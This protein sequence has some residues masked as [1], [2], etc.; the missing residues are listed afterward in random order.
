MRR[1]PVIGLAIPG[2]KL[3]HR[4]IGREEFQRA[5]QLLHARAVAADHGKADRRRLWPRRDRARQIG[6]H[7]AFGALGDIGE[8]QRAAGRQLFGGRSGR[9]LHASASARR[10]DLMRVEQPPA[11]FRRQRPARRSARHRGRGRAARSDARARPVRSSVRSAISASA[12]RPRMRSISRVPRCQQ[13][14]NSRLRR[15]SRPSLDR[16]VPVICRFQSKRQKPGRA[17]RG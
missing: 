17:G 14:N 8:G 3:Q 13:R 4:Q 12:K 15:S 7:E 5:G 6:N 11:I 10:N 16:V 1:H 9:R 2:R